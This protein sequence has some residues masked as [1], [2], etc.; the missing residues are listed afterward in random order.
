MSLWTDSLLR[1]M[2][3]WRLSDAQVATMDVADWLRSLGLEQ[4]EP[5]FR[6]NDWAVPP[7]LTETDLD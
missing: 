6:E 7:E 1:R 3:V 2:L 4:Y 5:T